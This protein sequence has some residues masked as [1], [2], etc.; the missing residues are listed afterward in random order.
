MEN[1]THQSLKD[2]AAGKHPEIIIFFFQFCANLKYKRCVHIPLNFS[3][4]SHNKRNVEDPFHPQNF[5][6]GKLHLQFKIVTRNNA[7]AYITAV[8]F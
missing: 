1:G 5:F 7:L 8:K 4:L 2:R 6:G 3:K